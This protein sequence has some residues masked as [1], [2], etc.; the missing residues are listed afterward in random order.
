[1]SSRPATP[2]DVDRICGELPH[3][4]FGVSW[5][6][7]PTWLVPEEGKGR[8]FV[9]YRKPHLTATDPATGQ[10]Y[11]DLL[12]VRTA[13]AADKQALVEGDGPFFDID[14]F[15]SFNAVLVQLSRLDE[16]TAAELREV[17]TD[18]WLAVAPKHLVREHLGRGR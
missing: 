14:H 17:I 2:D 4:R 11:T 8:G 3:T 16:I 13:D 5:G 15:R 18:A 6:D 7:V 1:M 12:V 9:L 10:P